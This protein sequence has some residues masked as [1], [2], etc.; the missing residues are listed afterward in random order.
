MVA[1]RK[2]GGLARSGR[3]LL[4]A[5]AC[6]AMALLG[7]CDRRHDVGPV[8]VSAIGNPPLLVDPSRKHLTTPSRLLLDA[9]AQ[10]LVRF[11][12][13][14]QIEPGL[15]ERWTIIDGGMSYIFRLRDA[16]WADG[17][18]VAASEVVTAL[19][20]QIA[21]ASGN[22][23]APFMTAVD[24]VVEMTPQV[25]EVRL[26][27]PRPDLLKL[28]AQPELA[29]FRA[30]A[31]GGSG[32][33]RIIEKYH[34]SILL[35]P[36]FDPNRA[37]SDDV[38]EPGP[39]DEVRLFGERA[40]LAIIR[41]ADHQSDMVSGGT[42]LDWPLVPMAQLAPANIRIDP[43]TG[44]FGFVVTNRQGFLADA[45]N[46]AAI[47]Q[48]I[49][50]PAIVAAFAP[51]WSAVEHTLPDR[52]DSA[53][54]PAVPAWSTLSLDDRRAGARAS[55][56]RWQAQHSGPVRLRLALP[57]GP[58]ATVLFGFVAAALQ[59]IG[60]KAERVALTD[61][62]DLRLV[63]DVAPYDSAR[64][65]LATAC[66]QCSDEARSALEAARLANN[67]QERGRQLAL[68]DAAMAADAG[69]IPIAQPLRWSLVS[70][71]LAA[72]QGNPRAWHPLNRLRPNTN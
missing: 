65:Y 24:E 19:R 23:L 7:G 6:L 2:F 38:E 29:L 47:S 43:A 3:W 52:L 22:P 63:D 42:F 58:G 13:A 16:E 67:L 39:K 45:G 5:S 49:D 26:S 57:K 66:V 46:R 37:A 60:V 40:S 64:W 31:L 62:A 25:I 32:P 72:W 12:A 34:S 20:R 9:T 1:T 21:P 53:E 55:V 35:R 69:F 70:L 54:T 30:R 71:R 61:R 17:T 15:A 14:G 10:G 28:F 51:G 4:P 44:L 8:V 11:D 36:S 68:A 50:R 59:S 27:R 48:A 56:L 18:P 41:F 33:F